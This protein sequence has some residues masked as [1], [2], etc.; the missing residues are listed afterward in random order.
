MP[1]NIF[2]YSSVAPLLFM[3]LQSYGTRWR[4]QSDFVAILLLL[5][6]NSKYF[7][8]GERSVLVYNAQFNVIVFGYMHSF[9]AI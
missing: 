7:F 1:L 2:F 3:L 6:I 5:R 8:S 4:Y 9:S